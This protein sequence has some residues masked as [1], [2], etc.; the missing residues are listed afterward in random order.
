VA[1]LRF[2]DLSLRSLSQGIYYDE[3]TPAFGIRIGKRRKTFF[4]VKDQTRSKITLAHFLDTSLAEARKKALLA[5]GSPLVKT[6]APTFPEAR[7]EYLAQGKWKTNS[8]EQI[9]LQLNRFNSTK[10][11]D[12]ITIKILPKL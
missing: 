12:Q 1:I 6:S 3:R 10:P 9:T 7:A 2:T 11:I 8:R 4:V 5:L